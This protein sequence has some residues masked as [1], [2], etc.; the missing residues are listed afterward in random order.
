MRDRL[1]SPWAVLLAGPVVGMT[2]FWLVYLVAEAACA[3][4]LDLVSSTALGTV[5][6]AATAAGAATLLL[7]A[8]RA[9]QLVSGGDENQRFMATTGLM[10][11]GLFVLFVL[12]LVAPAIGSALC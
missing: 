6:A 1:W 9:R 5:I 3:D 8:W 2:Y 7:Y 10:V 11:L 12:F 4:D